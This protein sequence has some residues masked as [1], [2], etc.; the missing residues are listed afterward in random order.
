MMVPNISN[1]Y[2]LGS[3]KLALMAMGD[4][5]NYLSIFYWIFPFGFVFIP[6]IGKKNGIFVES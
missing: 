3:L 5:G 6:L 1:N 4:N 2:F